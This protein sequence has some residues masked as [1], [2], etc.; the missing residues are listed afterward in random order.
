M[1][2]KRRQTTRD[3]YSDLGDVSAMFGLTPYYLYQQKHPK[4]RGILNDPSTIFGSDGT[5]SIRWDVGLFFSLKQI[6]NRCFTSKK[7][8]K[9]VKLEYIDGDIVIDF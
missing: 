5:T 2:P 1:V 9:P 4:T 3:L 8:E 6:C 7:Y